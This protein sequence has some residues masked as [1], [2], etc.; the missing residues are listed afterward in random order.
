MRSDASLDK[1]IRTLEQRI[2]DRR[3]AMRESLGELRLAAADAKERVRQRATSPAVWGGALLLGFIAARFAH[4][5]PKP[6]RAT[7]RV[8]RLQSPARQILGALLSVLLPVAV[9]VAQHS[10]GPWIAQGV[11]HLRETLAR[12]RAYQRAYRA[13]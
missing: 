5:R 4:R 3:V 10:A 8:E 9:R 7:L 2:S 13:Y 12:K 11:H 6:A 1:Q